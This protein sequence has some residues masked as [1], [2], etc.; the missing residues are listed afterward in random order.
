M[1]DGVSVIKIVEVGDGSVGKTCL[2]YRY[3]TDDFPTSYV[4]TVFDDYRV[5]IEVDG[6]KT[7]VQIVDTAGQEDY[8]SLRVLSY[9]DASVV[10]IAFSLVN[11]VSFANV[12]KR[13]I[14]EVREKAPDAKVM[15][16][17]TKLDLRKDPEELAKMAKRNLMPISTKEGEECARRIGAIAYHECSARGEVP[18][19]LKDLFDDAIR[20]NM[21]TGKE[22]SKIGRSR[23]GVTGKKNA[24]EPVRTRRNRGAGCLP[25]FF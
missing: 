16:V 4:P 9:P 24:P 25:A 22:N 21:Y 1:D 19:G 14:K 11:P 3:A 8:E 12:E 23:S 13:W 20:S 7:R 18:V 17:G 5:T 15:L 6:V 2:L 10:I